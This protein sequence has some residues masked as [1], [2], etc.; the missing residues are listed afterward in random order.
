[1]YLG[2]II[3]I[4]NLAYVISAFIFIIRMETASNYV[5]TIELIRGLLYMEHNLIMKRGIYLDRR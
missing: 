2:M 1:M 4:S 5:M 3:I